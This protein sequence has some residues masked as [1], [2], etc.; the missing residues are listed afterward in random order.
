M[1]CQR[2][3][4]RFWSELVDYAE[5]FVIAVSI[6]LIL[7]SVAFRTCTVDGDSMNKTLIDGQVIVVSDTFYSAKRGD[8]VVVHLTDDSGSSR[9]NK[10][11]VKRIIGVGGDTVTVDYLSQTE[12]TVTV[13]DKNGNTQTLKEK[14]VYL[15]PNVSASMIEGTYVVPEGSV[16]V[17]GDNRNNSLDSRSIGVIDERRILGRAVFR[18][19]PFTFF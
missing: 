14:Y 13:T 10:P 4:S 8:I 18:L 5:L 16:F 17:L 9:N 12:M 11:L 19:A 6:V 15:D 3:F 1:N 2:K 7:F